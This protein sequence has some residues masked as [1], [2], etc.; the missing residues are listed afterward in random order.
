MESAEPSNEPQLNA[1]L[2]NASDSGVGSVGEVTNDNGEAIT[3][4]VDQT[5][6]SVEQTS[7]NAEVSATD[8]GTQAGDHTVDPSI[9]NQPPAE[10]LT[11]VNV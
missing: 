6:D 3:D 1:D 4:N 2:N 11:Q 9:S 8:L 5:P 10:E 7:D